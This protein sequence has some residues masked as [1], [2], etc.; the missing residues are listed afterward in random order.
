M[1]PDTPQ[2]YEYITVED[3]TGKIHNFININPWTQ[4]FD[5]KGRTD[6]LMSYA[7]H[8]VMKNCHCDCYNFFYVKED[9]S[10]YLLNDFIFENLEIQAKKDDFTTDIVDNMVVRNVNILVEAN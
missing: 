10:Q 6:I 3:I 1:R 9:K 8:I 7:E 4:F 5:L 2:C